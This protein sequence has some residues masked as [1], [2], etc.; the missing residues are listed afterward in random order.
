MSG[1]DGATIVGAEVVAGH[2]GTAELVVRLRHENGAESALALDA[3]TGFE[4][5][6][7]AG[8]ESLD[9]LAGRAWI[10]IVKGL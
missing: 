7:A 2:D 8:V 5:M 1:S 6:R 9:R 10:E 3:G 4:L